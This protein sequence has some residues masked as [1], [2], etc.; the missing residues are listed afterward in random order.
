MTKEQINKVI[1]NHYDTL[2][3]RG[4]EVVGVFLYGSQNYGMQYEYSDIDTKAIIL[5]SFNDIVINKSLIST[6]S[7]MKKDLCDIKDIRLMFDNFLKQNINFLEIIF[8]EYKVINPKYKDLFDEVIQNREKIAKYNN[9]KFLNS[10]AGMAM[11][12]YKALEHPY[13][14]LIDEIE[15][16]GFCAKQMHHCVRL[17]E[18]MERYI[19]GEAFE[20]TLVPKNKEYIISLKRVGNNTL[21]EARTLCKDSLSKIDTMK[22]EYMETHEQSVDEDVEKILNGVVEKMLRQSLR[23]EL[24]KGE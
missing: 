21:E 9:Y 2:V 6:T 1:Q 5:P 11:Q 23:E 15:K 19:D 4:Y 24:L 8:T 12:K 16:Y 18:F 13:P 14:S 20:T 22:K 10:V 17:C 3:E 7:E